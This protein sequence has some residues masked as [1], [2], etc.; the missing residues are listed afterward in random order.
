LLGELGSAQLQGLVKQWSVSQI[1]NAFRGWEAYHQLEV[2]L[3]SPR[4]PNAESIEALLEAAFWCLND[5]EEEVHRR[6]LSEGKSLA[7]V[8]LSTLPRPAPPS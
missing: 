2:L 7:E 1:A 6:E 4:V 8:V 5:V 3:L